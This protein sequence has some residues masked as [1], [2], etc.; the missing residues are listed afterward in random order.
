MG[1]CRDNRPSGP[2]GRPARRRGTSVPAA[3]GLVVAWLALAPA[4]ANAQLA[5]AKTVQFTFRTGG[6]V[7]AVYT[8]AK[9]LTRGTRF[10]FGASHGKIKVAGK[11]ITLAAR[12]V[13]DGYLV[14]LDCNA[15]GKV[16]GGE[17]VRLSLIKRA[18]RFQLA[19]PDGDKRRPY[20][21]RLANV[22]VGVHLN[23]V[24]SFSG[25]AMTDGCLA[26][27]LGDE[28][29]WL[30]DD[31]LDGQF[32]QD[33]KDA[34][35][36]GGSICAVPLM[37]RHQVG[38]HHYVVDVTSG[39]GE[40]T[41]QRVDNLKLGR[42]Q[43]LVRPSLLTALV[44]T[45]E[46]NGAAYDVRVSGRTGIP[47]GNYKLAYAILS[48]GKRIAV[49]GPGPNSAAY[50]ITENAVNVLRFGPPCR[51][52]FSAYFHGRDQQMRVR[53]D[54]VPYGTGGERY[55][56]DFTGYHR[57]GMNPHV[58]FNN[59]RANL[60]DGYMS[61]DDEDR[62]LEFADWAP[63][64][65]TRKTGRIVMTCDLPVLGKAVGA[66]TLADI[67]DKKRAEAPK[68]KTP[69]VAVR[70]LPESPPVV[71]RTPKPKPTPAAPPPPPRPRPATRPARPRVE[72]P[73]Y[74]AGVLFDI[75]K[76]FLKQN[77]RAMGIAKLKEVIKKYPKTAAARQADDLLL[78]LE[79]E[80]DGT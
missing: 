15:D 75:A 61:Y 56:L 9:L 78:D 77:K 76:A 12:F 19:L 35:A 7:G 27:R 79:I 33:G 67:L 22:A 71:V 10:R 1:G 24:T 42:V 40:A 14:G 68:P 32:T 13:G 63:K 41:F 39:G 23:Q 2:A 58:T 54:I 36:F 70:K 21:L 37:K 17:W 3:P 30:F 16:L 49:A 73:E 26:G 25:R 18:A 59:G 66:R 51:L 50:A 6:P 45:D 11:D 29:V 4:V 31:N 48:A 28:Q 80:A 8:P 57:Y 20:G 55:H 62:L 47:P 65:F 72:D 52:T 46:A 69:T 34:V 44:L 74:D 38:K 43:T 64:G 53:T 60:T 5:D